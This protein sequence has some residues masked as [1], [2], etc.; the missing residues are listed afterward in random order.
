L[1]LLLLAKIYGTACMRNGVSIGILSQQ[2]RGEEAVRPPG[3][4]S[5]FHS[6]IQVCAG[7]FEVI[8]PQKHITACQQRIYVLRIDL[9]RFVP[10]PMG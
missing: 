1:F 3:I 9:E 2:Q 10:I 6:P 5:D 7:T 8:L 4:G